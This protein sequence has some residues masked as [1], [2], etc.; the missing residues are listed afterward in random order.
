MAVSPAAPGS[1]LETG[2]FRDPESRVFYA[3]GQVL[4]S[5]SGPGLTDWEKLKSSGLYD[6]L[7]RDG[8]LVATEQVAEA[9]VPDA[10]P[11]QW[12]GLLRHEL[13]PTI[14]YPYEWSFSQLKDAALLQLDL[15]LAALKRD[16]ILKDSTPYNVQFRGAQPTFIDNR[17]FLSGGGR[18]GPGGGGGGERRGGGG[19]GARPRGGRNC[20]SVI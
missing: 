6:E 16:M 13:I 8:R 4:R 17:A 1:R 20:A 2:S 15:L 10:L 3:N 9:D 18:R 11:G 12:T 14:T 19:G 5:L 7:A